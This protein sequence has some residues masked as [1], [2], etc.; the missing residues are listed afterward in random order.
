MAAY[1]TQF[2][3]PFSPANDKFHKTETRIDVTDALAAA[4]RGARDDAHPGVSVMEQVE[5]YSQLTRIFQDVFDEDSIEVTPELTAQDVEGWDSLTHVRLI[6]T[7][8]KAFKVRFSTSEIHRLQK[9]GDLAKLIEE[10]T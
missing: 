4:L 2:A 1:F 8:Q 6:M 9:V 3:V 7:I 5:I 10:R